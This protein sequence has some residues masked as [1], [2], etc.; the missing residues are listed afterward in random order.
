MRQS[1]R[2][3]KERIVRHFTTSAHTSE[4]LRKGDLVVIAIPEEMELLQQIDARLHGRVATIV[5]V[6]EQ[7]DEVVVELRPRKSEKDAASHP[8]YSVVAKEATTVH[9]PKFCLC[10]ETDVLLARMQKSQSHA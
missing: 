3:T 2:P 5:D 4:H 7:S 9:I 10:L 8:Y 1:H 6:N